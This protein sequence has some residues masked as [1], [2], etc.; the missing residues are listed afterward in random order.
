MRP[1]NILWLI[2]N[3]PSIYLQ[4]VG[5]HRESVYMS[6]ILENVKVEKNL[7]VGGTN[8]SLFA[9]YIGTI[10]EKFK[11]VKGECM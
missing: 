3:F 6:E 4:I 2:T 9:K 5:N 10:C 11:F 1:R 8:R 7:R